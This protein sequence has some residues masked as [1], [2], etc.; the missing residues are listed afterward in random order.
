MMFTGTRYV[1]SVF[2]LARRG[3]FCEYTMSIDFPYKKTSFGHQNP[4]KF[5][6]PAVKGTTFTRLRRSKIETT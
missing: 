1:K 5:P 6:P 2:S 4:E 3:K